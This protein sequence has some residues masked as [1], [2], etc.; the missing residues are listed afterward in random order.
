VAVGVH[1]VTLWSQLLALLAALA[2]PTLSMMGILPGQ[3][4]PPRPASGSGARV[5][6][7]VLRLWAV[8]AGSALGGVLVAAL[9]SQWLFM[10]EIREFLGV[11]LAHIV[12]VVLIGLMLAAADAPRGELWPRLRAWARQPLL[13]WYGIA[14]I[15]VGLAAVFILGRTGN[16]GLP[17]LGALELK[18]RVLLSHLA[19]V[20]PRT[21]E[22]LIGHPFMVL[23]FA[24]PALGL[25]RWVLP[26]ALIGAIGQ[27]GLVNSFSHIHTPIVYVLLRTL[28]ALVLGSAIGAGLVVLLLWS[29]RWWSPPGGASQAPGRRPLRA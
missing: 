6:V 3:G 1:H 27:V 23:A 16:A 4:A 18:S 24:L 17:V 21:K 14:V 8:S 29:R 9:L 13:L 7:S 2:F 22:Y 25:R 15:V 11:K 10:L 26:A 5:V 20:R 12:P 19:A 28:D